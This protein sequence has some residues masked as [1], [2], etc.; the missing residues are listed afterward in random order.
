M[1]ILCEQLLFRGF[2]SE[3]TTELELSPHIMN[4]KLVLQSNTVLVWTFIQTNSVVLQFCQSWIRGRIF[5]I[6]HLVPSLSHFF[7]PPLTTTYIVVLCQHMAQ[8][9]IKLLRVMTVHERSWQL[10]EL[11]LIKVF[12]TV[13]LWWLG[14]AKT[15]H[16]TNPEKQHFIKQ[17][18]NDYFPPLDP[19][20]AHLFGP[21]VIEKGFSTLATGE[22][23][24]R[25]VQVILKL[26]N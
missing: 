2:A 7:F 13:K 14:A 9:S 6:N 3:T 16:I 20:A 17:I 22:F 19:S 18:N 24:D 5:P 10:A 26:R 15:I 23:D 8:D 25:W 11:F 21:K 12:S 1:D 4:G